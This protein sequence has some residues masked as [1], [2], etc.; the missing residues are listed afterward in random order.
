MRVHIF[1]VHF[2]RALNLPKCMQIIW[3]TTVTDFIAA[4]VKIHSAGKIYKI[5]YARVMLML[6]AIM[7]VKTHRTE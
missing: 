4:D 2:E 1:G 7:T 3:I 6:Y 5:L